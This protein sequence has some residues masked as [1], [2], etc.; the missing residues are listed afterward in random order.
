MKSTQLHITNGDNTTLALQ[1]LKIDGDI[2]TWREML[3]EGKTTIDVGSESFWKSRFDFFSRNYKITKK[4]FI[5]STLKEFRNLC[6]HKYQEEIIL[7]FEHDLFCQINMIAVI[8]WLKKHRPNATIALVS[9]ENKKDPKKSL[10]LHKLA[11]KELVSF[12]TNRVVL[13][14]EDIGYADYIWQLYC[15]KSPLQLQNIITDPHTHFK[16]L[17]DA[18]EAHLQRFPT[19]KNGLNKIENTILERALA[20]SYSSKKSFIQKLLQ[21]QGIYG[22][23]AEQYEKK[24]TDLKGLFRSFSPVVL[25][26][27]GHDVL[28]KKQNYYHSIKNDLS[29]LGGSLKYKYLYNEIDG[30]LLKL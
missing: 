17:P 26:D 20:G 8:S 13:T 3:C 16:Y 9:P 15:S 30:K 1:K 18:I 2:V 19:I 24:I 11:Q 21:N 4:H 25:N 22:F 7:W 5:N 29:Y 23:G 27:L 28:Q 14:K 10:R 12:Y 6:N